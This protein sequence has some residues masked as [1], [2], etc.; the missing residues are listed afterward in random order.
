MGEEKGGEAARAGFQYQDVAA[1]YYFITDKPEF[2][3]KLPLELMIEDDDDFNYS[4]T[5]DDYSA[6]HYFQAKMRGTG[7]FNLS[8]FKD[9]FKS[10]SEFVED[11]NEDEQYHFHLVTNLSFGNNM[12][13]LIE[14]AKKC[15]QG[16]LKYDD[17]I[18]KTHYQQRNV[19]QLAD[20]S[21]FSKNS[22]SLKRLVWG[23]YGHSKTKE[24]MK[25]KIEDFIREANGPGQERRATQEIINKIHQTDSGP[26]T[27]HEFEELTDMR[28]R[29]GVD[30]STAN[31]ADSETVETLSEMTSEF[32]NA[33]SGVEK[34]YRWKE[35]TKQITNTD[36]ID[37]MEESLST[38]LLEYLDD[39][40]HHQKELHRLKSISSETGKHLVDKIDIDT[41]DDQ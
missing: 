28:L 3:Q 41:G 15:R 12:A 22:G 11:P 8:D 1:A 34:T 37:E 38:D 5:F 9:A 16:R 32:D 20:Y 25:S 31:T 10:F 29:K 21:G 23:T 18:D 4:I 2:M 14:D 24:L 7:C 40:E 35:A 17:I 36:Q 13:S 19:N 26:I 30:D 33:D 27:R 39:I 6:R